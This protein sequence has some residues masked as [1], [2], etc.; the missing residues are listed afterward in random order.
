MMR[1]ASRGLKLSS[2]VW[3][4]VAGNESLDTI[5]DTKAAIGTCSAIASRGLE[6]R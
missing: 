2:R 5:G 1:E 3:G 6:L 4:P